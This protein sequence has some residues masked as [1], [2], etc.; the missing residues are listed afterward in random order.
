MFVK[1]NGIYEEVYQLLKKSK[2]NFQDN[3]KEIE[4]LRF[5]L[6]ILNK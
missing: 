2:E 1:N 4:F 3:E 5:Q 6:S